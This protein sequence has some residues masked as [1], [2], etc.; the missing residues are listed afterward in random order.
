MKR[1]IFLVCVFLFCISLIQFAFAEVL[2]DS[3]TGKATSQGMGLSI[4]I[5][6][7]IPYITITSPKNET[8]LKNESLILNYT[9]IN[10]DYVWYN[11]DNSDNVTITSSVQF[12]VPQGQHVLY[13]F[14]NNSNDTVVSSVRFTVNSSKFIIF[15]GNYSGSNK[16]SSTNFLNYSH[17]EIQ[18]LNNIVIENAIYGKI[19]FNEYINLT[20]DRNYTDNLLDIDSN[21]NISFNRIEL[22]STELPNFNKSATLWLYNLTFTTPRILKDGVVCPSTICVQESYSGGTLKFNVTGFSVYSSEETPVAEPTP[23]PPS[24][25]GGGG[26]P[27]EKKIEVEPEEMHIVLKQGETTS[28]NIRV[29]NLENQ[30]LLFQLEST[31]PSSIIRLNETEFYINPRRSKEVNV[32]FIAGE[33]ILPDIYIGKIIV[34]TS[35][36]K[37]EILVVVEVISKSPLFDIKLEV[38]NRFKYVL[39][40]EDIYAQIE[41]YNLGDYERVDVVLDYIIQ[42]SDGEEIIK[43][44]Q[45]IAVETSTSFIKNIKIPENI[46]FGRYVFYIRLTYDSKVASASDLFNVG[47]KPT[48]PFKSSMIT[49]SIILIL[50]VIII[51][52]EIRKIKKEGRI[53]KKVD[54]LSFERAN[55]SRR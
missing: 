8:Y 34:T 21:I 26:A 48:I 23:T 51:L 10:G 32:D 16:G 4:S 53:S 52:L 43:E 47:V 18:N 42:N 35:G 46:P 17:E 39:P 30:K 27:K 19:K 11:V 2:E 33:T 44:Q 38:P 49:L 54:I 9:L 50:G 24:G 20:N 12:N 31:L 36:I 5:Y 15:F 3:I 29:N 37:K 13:I 40:G 1:G 55:V 6:T 7:T 41:L 25:G 14:A 45:T 22:N 28:R